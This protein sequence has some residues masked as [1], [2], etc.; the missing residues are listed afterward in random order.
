MGAHMSGLALLGGT[1]VIDRALRPYNS[2]GAK[3]IE[4]ANRVL[5]SGVL[6]KFV[7]AWCEDFYGGPA[8]QELE[9][10]WCETFK[11]SH[12][13]SVNSATSGI[14]AAL[15]AVG[16]GPGDEVIVP[17]YTMSATAMAPLVY[18][19]IPV[20][21]DIEPD[22]FCLDPAAVRKSLT[23]RTKAILV[24]NLFG[25]A[26]QLKALREI[27]DEHK[28][29][30]IEDNAQ[31]PLA[32][33]NDKFA[34][35]IG[36][37]GIFSLNYHKHFHSGEGGI[38]VTDCDNLAKRL[39]MIRNHGENVIEELGVQDL[40]NMIGYNYRMTEL[41][42]AIAIEQLKDAELHVSKRERVARA[43]TEAV[44]DL[45]GITAP[46]VRSGCRH[47]YYVWAAR[48]DEHVVGVSREV[49]AEALSA[50]GFP[51]SQGYVRPLYMLP[52]FQK[53]IAIGSA[54]FPFNL[55]ERAYY[56]GMCPVVERMHDKEL[57]EFHPC[58]YE[59]DDRQ[60]ELLCKALKKVFDNRNSLKDF[61]R[62]RTDRKGDFVGTSSSKH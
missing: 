18:G 41:T 8:V 36:H 48:Y 14:Y 56:S 40:T 61:E 9:K 25:H 42:A 59:L 31:G 60:I 34:G 32:T 28:I 47:V 54:G 49:I 3:E 4:A 45:D 33:E 10:S 39:H 19:G 17:P 7:G 51:N 62:E 53:R 35:T 37:I 52:V 26:A 29:W 5:Q 21:A 57:L 20:F 27:A 23:P 24:V 6:S 22:T 44:S 2:I 13:I 43:L 58:T 55:T 12:A 38:C 46:L 11:V 1:P 16:V 50:E 15:G 30:L